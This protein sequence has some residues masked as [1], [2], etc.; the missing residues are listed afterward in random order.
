MIMS[1][2]NNTFLAAAAAAVGATSGADVAIVDALLAQVLVKR[3][4]GAEINDGTGKVILFADI[5]SDN[6]VGYVTRPVTDSAGNVKLYSDTAAAMRLSRSANLAT[7]AVISFTTY[8]KPTS[9]GDPLDSLKAR[10]KG[11]CSK[12]FA[13]KKQVDMI[14]GKVAVAVQFGWDTSTG[15]TAAE[16]GDLLARQVVLTEWQATMG[17]LID[18]LAGRLTT[19]GVEPDTV[20]PRPALSSESSS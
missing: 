7:G 16:Y 10:Y 9:V 19:A 6:E 3:I 8:K 18:D 1:I 11:A 17:S 5:N 15:A 14:T 4:R 20:A 2:K 13:A 12:G